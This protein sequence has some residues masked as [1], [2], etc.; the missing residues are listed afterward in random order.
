MLTHVDLFSGIGGFA[1]AAG[2]A[3]F[4]TVAF[5]EIDKFCQEVLKKHWPEI[6]IHDDIKT[7]HWAGEPRPLL[8]TGGP[9]C[10]SVSKAGKRNGAKDDRFLWPETIR[11]ISEVGPKWIVL[12]NPI[13]FLDMGLDP[14]LDEL[15]GLGYSTGTGV[16]RA[17]AVDAPHAR[18]RIWMV[19]N[20]DSKG[21]ERLY[22]AWHGIS[23]QLSSRSWKK[24]KA[25][26]RVD[27]VALGVPN[28]VDRLKALG[29]AIVP[30]V[31]YQII[32]A[33]AEIE[34]GV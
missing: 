9:P 33:I 21:L 28:R 29:N 26:P 5:C 19:A 2:W 24:W 27:R 30:Q 8:L 17:M 10:Q 11:V 23:M 13:G 4:R 15:E 20:S 14:F 6:P 31:A 18:A 7:F 34:G 32:K 12:E 16:I 25:E 22:D 1:L 3:G